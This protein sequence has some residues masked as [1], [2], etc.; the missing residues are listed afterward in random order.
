MV[1]ISP[2]LLSADFARL[3]EEIESIKASGAEMLHL[4]VMDGVFVPNISFGVPV[5]SSI[6]KSSDM[7]FDTHLMIVDP[8]KYVEKFCDIGSD[9]VTFHL[10]ASK[11]PEKCIELIKAKGKK[12]AISIKPATPAEA[13]FPYLESC[14]MILVMT[15]EPGFGGQSLILDCVEKV[16]KIKAEIV[17][18]GLDV[19]IQVDGGVNSK[20]ARMLAEAGADIL[21]AGS[22]VFL[23]DDRRAAVDALR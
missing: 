6:R 19:E 22:A 14:D 7:F 23:A 9:L 18:R 4:D 12:A 2:S 16:K 17:A 5:I 15:V 3:N 10:E 11:V 20:N 1:K 13:V 21:V 8:E